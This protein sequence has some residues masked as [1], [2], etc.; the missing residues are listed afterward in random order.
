MTSSTQLIHNPATAEATLTAGQDTSH[1]LV[2]GCHMAII[3][4]HQHCAELQVQQG[5][6]LCVTATGCGVCH[7]CVL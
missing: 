3:L 5:L 2:A 1:G 4:Q 7:V 6:Q